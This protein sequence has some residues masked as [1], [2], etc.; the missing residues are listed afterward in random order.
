MPIKP[1][2]CEQGDSTYK[3]AS[4]SFQGRNNKKAIIQTVSPKTIRII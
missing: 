2:V 4:I 1:G 3:D